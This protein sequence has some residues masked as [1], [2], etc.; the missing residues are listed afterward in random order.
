MTGLTSARIGLKMMSETKCEE[1]YDGQ[2]LRRLGLMATLP[3]CPSEP[4]SA[5]DRVNVSI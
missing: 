2:D 3:N 5:G 4:L 1:L